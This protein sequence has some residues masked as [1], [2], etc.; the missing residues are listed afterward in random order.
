MDVPRFTALLEAYG[1]DP[2]R[3]PATERNAALAYSRR[4][5]EAAATLER[6]ANLDTL[7]DKGLRD[8]SVPDDLTGRI[9]ALAPVD[10]P[11]VD[12]PVDNKTE[13]V[14]P[15][16]RRVLPK[17]RTGWQRIAA[18]ALIGITAGILFSE[19]RQDR[20]DS[21]HIEIVAVTSPAVLDTPVLDADGLL[22]FDD[23]TAQTAPPQSDLAALSFTGFEAPT[24]ATEPVSLDDGAGSLANL[25]LL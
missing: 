15:L 10:I 21:T 12:I 1:A 7:L 3:W 19:I 4:S 14:V 23:A 20:A 18:T 11:L 9:L 25:D 24:A 22:A 2:E 13:N 16:W 6:A 8:V 5:A 17:D